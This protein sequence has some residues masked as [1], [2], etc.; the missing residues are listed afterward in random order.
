MAAPSGI[1]WIPPRRSLFEPGEVVMFPRY[2]VFIN[3]KAV[4]I[5]RFVSP[6]HRPSLP[7][8]NVSCY[9][10]L[11]EADSCPKLQQGRIKY[12]DEK[13]RWHSGTRDFPVCGAVLQPIVSC[14][15]CKLHA[16]TVMILHILLDDRSETAGKFWNVVLE[17][18]GEDQLDRSCEKWI[19]ITYS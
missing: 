6:T 17:K 16:S 1:F 13:F 9:S 18:D 11:L 8:R 4:D 19:S 12:A 7:P 2:C 10:F 14:K 15:K 5:C 3:L